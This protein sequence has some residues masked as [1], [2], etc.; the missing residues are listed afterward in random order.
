MIILSANKLKKAYGTDVVLEDA[1]FA[2]NAGEKIGIIGRNGAGKTTLLNI[3]AGEWEATEGEFFVSQDAKIGYL[4]QRDNFFRSDTLIKAIDDIF[5]DI[6]RVEKEIEEVT[7]KIDESRHSGEEPSEDLIRNLDRLHLE[8]ERL[9][10]YTYKS[11]ITGILTSMAFSQA[12]YQKKISELSGGEKTR[13]A[14]AALLLEKPDI[15]LL[16][17]P[18]NHLDIDTLRWLEQY[19]EAYKGTVLIVSHDR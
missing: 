7:A 9:G 17:E 4:K 6:H 3:L 16:D 11:E 19:L 1:S 14:L 15:L 8:Y 13:L 12:D 10:G 18:T 5:E 2:I